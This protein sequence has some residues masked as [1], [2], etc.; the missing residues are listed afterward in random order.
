[1]LIEGKYPFEKGWRTEGEITALKT[2]IH[3]RDRAIFFDLIL[4]FGM[5][6]I[7]NILLLVILFLVID[8]T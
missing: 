2:V 6:L 7:L 8:A 4:I 3:K 1:M 5:G